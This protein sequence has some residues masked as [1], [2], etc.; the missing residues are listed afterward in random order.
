MCSL[1]IVQLV[2]VAVFVR[3]VTGGRACVVI[4]QARSRRRLVAASACSLSTVSPADDRTKK[5]FGRRHVC[6]RP[7]LSISRL[8]SSDT[9][10]SLCSSL[11][12]HCI[13][14]P[15]TDCRSLL[16]I[17]FVAL[18]WLDSYDDGGASVA[19]DHDDNG[20]ADQDSTTDYHQLTCVLAPCHELA[21]IVHQQSPIHIDFNSCIYNERSVHECDCTVLNPCASCNLAEAS[22]CCFGSGSLC[23]PALFVLVPA[24][25]M[26]SPGLPDSCRPKLHDSGL[27]RPP[28]LHEKRTDLA[29]CSPQ[30]HDS[31]L[32]AGFGLLTERRSRSRSP[33][34]ADAPPPD[35]YGELT[36]AQHRAACS[37]TPRRTF[38]LKQ[39]RCRC[40]S[41]GLSNKWGKQ[42]SLTTGAFAST[43]ISHC[44]S[45]ASRC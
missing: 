27:P 26:T 6:R 44:K 8:S 36:E 18:G 9:S 2:A 31:G 17:Q 19:G 20:E 39:C 4:W 14:P 7:L 29:S 24:S 25:P 37:P 33:Q 38:T 40:S 41:W 3:H 16:R 21:F 42:R 45:E 34:R 35:A 15:K 23:R 1:K 30:L 22:S 43:S 10:L 32:P 5:A 11:W 28:R 13:V 12:G